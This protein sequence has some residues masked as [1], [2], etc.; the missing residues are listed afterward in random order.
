VLGF[1]FGG[2][3]VSTSNFLLLTLAGI[4][5]TGASNGLNEI[6]EV[7][8]DKL[9][10]RTALRPLPMGRMSKTEAWIFC[11]IAGAL[12]IFIFTY[13]FNIQTGVLSAISLLLYAF[14]YTPM[15]KK[16]SFAVFVGAIPGALPPTIG[17]VA[18]TGLLDSAALVLFAIQFFWQFAH[19]WAIAWVSYEDYL[20]AGIMLLPDPKGKTKQS[21]YYTFVYTFAL[22]PLGLVPYF[23]SIVNLW[24]SLVIVGMGIYF[25]YL[26]FKFFRNCETPEADSFARKVMF[27]SFVYLPVVQVAIWLGGK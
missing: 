15:K 14:V 16:S 6:F 12:G 13:F 26:S 5:V 11:L 7:E 17:Y 3:N 27:G 10:N 20:K 21:A 23:M 2:E 8:T 25:T 4:L 1:L 18:S 19:F 9:M 24:G 22:I